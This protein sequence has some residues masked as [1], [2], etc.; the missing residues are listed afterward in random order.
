VI[1]LHVLECDAVMSVKSVGRIDVSDEPFYSM[2]YPEGRGSGFRP[3]LAPIYKT[4]RFHISEDINSGR[5]ILVI[6]QKLW[7]KNKF[8]VFNDIVDFLTILTPISGSYL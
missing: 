1:F 8:T 7:G 6:S 3:T 5:N 4:T 2:F